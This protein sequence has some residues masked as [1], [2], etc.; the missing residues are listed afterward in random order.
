MKDREGRLMYRGIWLNNEC[1]HRYEDNEHS[2]DIHKQRTACGKQ[3]SASGSGSDRS[4]G[5]SRQ[6]QGSSRCK[7]ARKSRRGALAADLS[8]CSS[9]ASS[10]SRCI[11]HPATSSTDF[12]GLSLDCIACF[13]LARHDVVERKR[14]AGDSGWRCPIEVYA[15]HSLL[16]ADD[17]ACTG[18]ADNASHEQLGNLGSLCVA[19]A[20]S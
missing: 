20:S 4:R 1:K 19:S 2:R 13:S 15:L 7:W 16:S 9:C 5:R 12:A 8:G 6:R 14:A 3:S 17:N 10:S 18:V 11:S